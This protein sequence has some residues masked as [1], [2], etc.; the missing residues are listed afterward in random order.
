MGEWPTDRQAMRKIV[1]P[2]RSKGV[3]VELSRVR[4]IANVEK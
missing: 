3:G 1:V 4:L 2:K